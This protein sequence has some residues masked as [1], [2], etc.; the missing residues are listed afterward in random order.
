MVAA[1]AAGL[2]VS[3]IGPS[4]LRPPSWSFLVD[5]WAQTAFLAT[6]LVFVLASMLVPR[7]MLGMKPWDLLLVGVA[8]LAALAARAAVLFLVMP[9]CA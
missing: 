5:V 3:A 9:L 4:V 1:A 2:T 8:V 7:L 6:S